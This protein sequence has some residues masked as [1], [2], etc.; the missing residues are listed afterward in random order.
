MTRRIAYE[1]NDTGSLIG[2]IRHG[3]AVALLPASLFENPEGVVFVPVRPRAPQ[4]LTA[5]AIPSNRRPSAAARALLQTL[6]RH[7]VAAA[8]DLDG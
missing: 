1:I 8:G 3:L 5:I 4:F 6:R 2:F 7:T